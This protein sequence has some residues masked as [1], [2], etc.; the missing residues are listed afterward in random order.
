MVMCM[1]FTPV[2]LIAVLGLVPLGCGSDVALGDTST[3][4]DWAKAPGFDRVT[5]VKQRRTDISRL[6]AAA[7]A[8]L[9]ER[10]CQALV[11]SEGSKDEPIGPLI[12]DAVLTHQAYASG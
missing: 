2:A 11:G 6:D 1:R 3:C 12:D 9:V 8:G 5:Y 7:V 10:R 4:V